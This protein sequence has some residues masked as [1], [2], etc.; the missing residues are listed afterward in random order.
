MT[1]L[2][3]FVPYKYKEYK[4]KPTYY[5]INS[6]DGIV[7]L[8]VLLKFPKL[9]SHHTVYIFYPRNNEYS[10]DN[11]QRDFLTKKE[12]IALRLGFNLL[13]REGSAADF[14]KPKYPLRH[15]TMYMLFY[16][17]LLHVI[18]LTCWILCW[19]VSLSRDGWVLHVHGGESSRMFSNRWLFLCSRRKSEGR[20]NSK[21]SD[22]DLN[23]VSFF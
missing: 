1:Y 16:M 8:F 23:L 22:Q 19:H 15:A 13:E 9:S 12:C 10:K 5:A 3:L 6:A 20:N 21:K 11:L 14:A 2:S 7:L 18:S 17:L 4:V